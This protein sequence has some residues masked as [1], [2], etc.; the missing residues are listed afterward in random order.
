MVATAHSQWRKLGAEFGG[1]KKK[2]CPPQIEKFEGDGERLT[3]S[4]N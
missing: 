3:V 1:T 4:W 2:F